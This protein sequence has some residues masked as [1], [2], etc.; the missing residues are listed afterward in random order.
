MSVTTESCETRVLF[1][2][3]LS[4]VRL[5]F[6]FCESCETRILFLSSLSLVRLG[7]VSV[8]TESCEIKFQRFRVGLLLGFASTEEIATPT[9]LSVSK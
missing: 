4:L 7:F 1:L 3:P 9:A 2:L 6:C 8:I 5:G